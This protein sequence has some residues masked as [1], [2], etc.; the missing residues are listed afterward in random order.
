MKS[1]WNY[2]H[3]LDATLSRKSFLLLSVLSL[4]WG[5]IGL[6]VWF[7]LHFFVLH[8]PFWAFV[9]VGWPVVLFGILGGTLYLFNHRP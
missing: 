2:V 6:L 3:Q 4:V 9:F 5:C 8:S 7:C 1:L